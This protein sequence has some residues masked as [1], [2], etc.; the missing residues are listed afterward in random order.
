MA[1]LTAHG[2]RLVECLCYLRVHLNCVVLFDEDLVVPDLNLGLDPVREDLAQYGLC[3]V[4]E[5]PITAAIK[6]EKMVTYSLGSLGIS[7]I[8]GSH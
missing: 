7:I 5:I 2:G 8:S 4:A 1:S 6:F 3:H